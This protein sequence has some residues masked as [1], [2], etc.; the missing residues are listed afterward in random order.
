MLFLVG[1][2][3]GSLWGYFQW[4]KDLSLELVRFGAHSLWRNTLLNLDKVGKALDVFQS[5]VSDFVD[6]P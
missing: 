1:C 2:G 6:F 5:D 3:L 4:D